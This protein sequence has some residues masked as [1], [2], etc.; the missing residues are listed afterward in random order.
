MAANTQD[1]LNTIVIYL[2]I[3]VGILIFIIGLI[4]NCL[5]IYVFTRPIYRTRPT[6]IYLLAFSI[7]SLIQLI[8]TLLPRIISDG[9]QITFIHNNTTYCQARN[10]ISASVTL[11]AI[12]CLCLASI[13]QLISTSRHARIRA[14]WTSKT[15]A[16]CAIGI[17]IIVWVLTYLPSTLYVRAV[18]NNCVST[19]RTASASSSYG[20]IPL[21]YT[22]CPL[23]VMIYSNHGIIHNL[24]E[25]PVT[26][27]T[28]TNKRLIRQ[29]QRMLFVQS[30]IL[31]LSGVPFTVLTVYSTATATVAKDSLRMSIENLLTHISRLFFYLNYISSFYIYVF[32]SSDFRSRLFNRQNQIGTN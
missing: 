16:F 9:F 14:R 29:V 13:N 4:G 1:V 10:L 7:T 18:N 24:R 15:V 12:T 25:T 28:M 31:I 20:L 11:T 26:V 21:F 30:L 22:I 17:T 5:N 6:N 32:M 23:I 3:I 19:N 2:N 27:L 8:H